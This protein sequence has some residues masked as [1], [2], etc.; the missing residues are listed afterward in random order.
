MDLTIDEYNI[1]ELVR[2]VKLDNKMPL[3]KTKIAKH[4]KQLIKKEKRSNV[5]KLYKAIG[6][7]LIHHYDDEDRNKEK[8]NAIDDLDGAYEPRI[9][10]DTQDELIID[11]TPT[12]KKDY[13]NHIVTGDKNP[14]FI[15]YI[16]ENV[17]ISS[18][19]RK[20]KPSSV[21]CNK[22]IN[23]KEIYSS[24][25][26]I[27]D[28]E[29]TKKDVLSIYVTDVS[30]PRTW[31]TFDSEYGTT[32]FML[33]N[34]IYKIDNG[35]Y[36]S[37]ELVAK[38]NLLND[39]VYMKSIYTTV[40]ENRL[41]N[42]PG[43]KLTGLIFNYN[44]NTNKIMIENKIDEDREI[45]WYF[46]TNSCGLNKK[47]S[48]INYNLGVLLGFTDISYTILKSSTPDEDVIDPITSFNTKKKQYIIEAENVLDNIG[49]THFFVSI[50]EFSNNKPN[51]A[52]TS[53]KIHSDNYKLPDYYNP[54]TMEISFNTLNIEELESARENNKL[55]D[56]SNSCYPLPENKNNPI[57]L[58]KNRKFTILR[59][60]EEMDR[61]KYNNDEL[62]LIQNINI[63]D[64]M[65]TIPVT[66]DEMPIIN[67]SFNE[68]NNKKRVYFGPIRLSKMR[69]R[70][71]NDKGYLVNLNGSNWAFKMV[72][73][74]LYQ[75]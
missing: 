7:H 5:K 34:T 36:T 30:I 69:I 53:S 49:S 62:N 67:W 74:R 27:M 37:Q 20:K 57:H 45:K 64:V 41:N 46:K 72:V 65:A 29:T 17:F 55:Y 15:N 56:N 23:S 59:L 1:D 22:V 11:K 58:T 70:L 66:K 47:G 21:I 48:K 9:Y 4:I 71:F 35:N 54:Q 18:N 75:L 43:I 61:I 3:N 2:I 26:F 68:E 73:K 63:P 28:L 44:V 25:D 16:H 12:I 8:L 33:D 52:I 38:L 24:T 6:V 42:T 51:P 10:S 19:M 40:N 14:N 39:L 32:S 31:Y 60:K 50:D 13:N